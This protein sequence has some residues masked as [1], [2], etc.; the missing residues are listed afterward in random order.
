MIE[1]AGNSA[2]ATNIPAMQLNKTNSRLVT[3]L[4]LLMAIAT[5]A[6]VKPRVAASSSKGSLANTREAMKNELFV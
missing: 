3:R 6:P 1:K 4:K 5:S 2:N